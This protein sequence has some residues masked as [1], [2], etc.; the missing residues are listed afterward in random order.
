MKKLKKCIAKGCSNLVKKPSWLSNARYD[1]RKFCCR[2]CYFDY[3]RENQSGWWKQNFDFRN[4]R[5]TAEDLDAINALEEFGY[6]KDEEILL[7][8]DIEVN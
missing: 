3:M 4:R 7:P 6:F 2:K 5:L 1:Q 8:G